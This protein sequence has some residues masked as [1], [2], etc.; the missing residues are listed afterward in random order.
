MTALIILA[1]GESSRLGQPKQN[2]LFKGQTLLQRAVEAGLQSASAIIY[3]VLGANSG[4][5]IPVAGAVILH[6]NEWRTGM[7]SSIK[8]AMKEVDNNPSVDSAIIMLCDQ[9]FV[10]SEILNA[11]INKQTETCKPI[12]ASK[13]NAAIG[14]PALFARS[15]FEEL[16]H[17]QGNEGAKKIIQRHIASVEV[18]SFEQGSMDIDTAEDYEGLKKLS[19]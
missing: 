1:A 14:V 9:P 6:N 12:V 17:L 5:I 3:V 13:Y 2:L 18:I 19:D 15:V 4:S 7:S 10:T 8:K 16:L 11:L